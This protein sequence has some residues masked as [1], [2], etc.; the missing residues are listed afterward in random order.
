MKHLPEM[1]MTCARV[2][3]LPPVSLE[4]I[5]FD[6]LAFRRVDC[7]AAVRLEVSCVGCGLPLQDAVDQ[8]HQL[9]EFVNSVVAIAVRDGGVVTDPF[10]L[11]E[12]GVL[13]LLLPVIEE[14]ALE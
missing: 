10:K 7:T 6:R 9:D 8:G 3:V 13:A 11:V 5:R 2:D 12:D 4:E 14:H 1:G